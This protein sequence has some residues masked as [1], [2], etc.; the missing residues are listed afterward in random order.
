MRKTCHVDLAPAEWASAD[1]P[2]VAYAAYARERLAAMPPPVDPDSFT[3]AYHLLHLSYLVVS[4]LESRIHRPRG[5][6]LPGFRLMFKLWLLG[7]TQ[8]ARLADI[9]VMSRSAVTNALNTL[10]RSGLIERRADDE[11]R[12]AVHVALTAQGLIA[13][14]E[15]FA[16][17]TGREAEWFAVLD[18]TERATLADLLKRVVGAR[19]PVSPQ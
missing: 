11:D 10:E 17:Q 14:Q 13:V 9:S 19:P 6:T 7:P 5:W 16:E 12:R 8:P 4:D 1:R 3:L 2:D 18:A 15:A